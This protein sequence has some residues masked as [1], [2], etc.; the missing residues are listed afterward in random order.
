MCVRKKMDWKREQ[1]LKEKN[2]GKGEN[3]FNYFNGIICL[4]EGFE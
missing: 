4:F 1:L 3:F 2:K